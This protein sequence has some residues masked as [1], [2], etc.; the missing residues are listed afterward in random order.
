MASHSP[1]VAAVIER[2]RMMR[3]WTQTQLAEAVGVRQQSVS[4]WENGDQSPSVEH[5]VKALRALEV[6]P[7]E[8][9]D[10]LGLGDVFDEAA[11]DLRVTIR[12]ARRGLEPGGPSAPPEKPDTRPGRGRSARDDRRDPRRGR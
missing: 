12:R 7:V 1:L 2:Y 5:A 10:A 11:S 4:Q 6:P 3:G 8:I 9:F